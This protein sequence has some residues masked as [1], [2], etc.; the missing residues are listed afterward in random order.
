V[1]GAVVGATT[2]AVVGS[3][4]AGARVRLDLGRDQAVGAALRFDL[5]RKPL[6]EAAEAAG[7]A[8]E[9]GAGVDL[10]ADP[11]PALGLVRKLWVSAFLETTVPS[12]C[13][14]AACAG[15]ATAASASA[16]RTST[17]SKR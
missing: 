9:A 5:D 7:D 11:V 2:T 13:R 1:V 6:V 14:T 3:A 12:M 16:A 8:L 4:A 15:S 17:G 10:D